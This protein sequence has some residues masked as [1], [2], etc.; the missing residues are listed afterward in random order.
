MFILVCMILQILALNNSFV[1]EPIKDVFSRL[2]G[3]VAAL[4]GILLL[5]LL[6]AILN[7]LLERKKYRKIRSLDKRL[8]K[9]EKL[10]AKK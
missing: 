2:F 3:V 1:P 8:E 4:G 7:F 5:Y 9:I 10:L 6:F